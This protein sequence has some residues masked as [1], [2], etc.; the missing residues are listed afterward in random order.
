VLWWHKAR[1]EERLLGGRYPGYS[2]Y[3]RRV[4]RRFVPGVI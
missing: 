2:D 4:K 1:L 3:M